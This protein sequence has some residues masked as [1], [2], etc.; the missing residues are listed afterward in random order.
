MN[1]STV[2]I[3]VVPQNPDRRPLQYLEQHRIQPGQ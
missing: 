2:N 1:L 3:L